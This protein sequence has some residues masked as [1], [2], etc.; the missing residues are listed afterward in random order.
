MTNTNGYAEST[1]IRPRGDAW[2]DVTADDIWVFIDTIILWERLMCPY[3]AFFGIRR[4]H[5]STNLFP[6]RCHGDN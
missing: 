1:A 4:V 2:K 5:T 6:P 3:A